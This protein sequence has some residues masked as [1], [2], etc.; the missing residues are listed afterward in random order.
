MLKPQP[1]IKLSGCTYYRTLVNSRGLQVRLNEAIYV[2]R[3]INDKVHKNSN[4]LKTFP[5]F[6]S[7][8]AFCVSYSNLAPAKVQSKSNKDATI[9]PGAALVPK[10]AEGGQRK[11]RTNQRKLLK[12]KWKQKRESQTIGGRLNSSNLLQAAGN[13]MNSI[14]GI[15]AFSVPNDFSSAQTDSVSFLAAIMPDHMRRNWLR[16]EERKSSFFLTDSAIRLGC[17]TVT[18]CSGPHCLT[19]CP[20]TLWL[21]VA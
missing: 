13:S 1:S 12:R 3:L 19:H 17:S 14:G 5:S 4:L 15:C 21:D 6:F 18:N 11:R 20:W 9:L 8:K 10:G 16:M 7:T 2:E